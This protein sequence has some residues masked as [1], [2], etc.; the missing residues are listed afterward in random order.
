MAKIIGCDL[1]TTN[2]VIAIKQADVKV[3]Q[4]RENQDSIPSV[5]G[6]H[7]DQIIVGSLAVDRM[8]G[9]P[10]NTIISIKRLMGRAFRDP[11]VERVRSR[12]L[13]K[14]VLPAE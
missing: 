4:S 1:G 14:V 5:V 10:D 9:A 12:Y 6:S 8:A 7:K 13:Y 11:E 3:L 2:S